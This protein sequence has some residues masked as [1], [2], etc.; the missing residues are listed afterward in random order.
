MHRNVPGLGIVLEHVQHA[1]A[2]LVRQVQVQQDRVGPVLRGGDEALAGG[3]GEHALVAQLVG[4]IAQ[5][6]A[7]AFVVLDHQDVAGLGIEHVAVVV[8]VRHRRQRAR[9]RRDARRRR[10]GRSGGGLWLRLRWRGIC[11]GPG[12]LHGQGQR[13]DAAL[14][15]GARDDQVAAQQ[16]REIAGD[17][18]AQA[19]AAVLAVGPAVGL[20]EGLED[21]VLLFGRD[22][23]A[24][25]GDAEADRALHRAGH[26]P[27][28]HLALVGELERVRQQ[29]LQDLANAAAVGLDA[30]RHPGLDGADQSQAL[31]LRHRLEVAQKVVDHRPD[32]GRLR[33]QV[34]LAGLDGGEVE[35]VVDQRQQ[36]FAAGRDRLRVLHLLLAEVAVL[37]VGQELGEDLRGVERRA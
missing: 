29:V 5:D 20:A 37:V 26:R 31:L 32:R 35:D 1:E 6:A 4:Q 7:E 15:R 24:L 11:G 23:D 27:Q 25:I 18:E 33:V 13:E 16:P 34:D 30:F 22:A 14:A 10:R 9:G 19:G 12:K 17:G 28:H 36:V 21:H 3:G 8:D 2:G